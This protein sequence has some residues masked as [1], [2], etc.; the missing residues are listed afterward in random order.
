MK[1][2]LSFTLL[3]GMFTFYAC[4]PSNE[5]KAAQEKTEQESSAAVK[6]SMMNVAEQAAMETA[7]TDST[8]NADSSKMAPDTTKKK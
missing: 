3:A 5:E 7:K 6:D 2:L 4:G 8:A 1:K